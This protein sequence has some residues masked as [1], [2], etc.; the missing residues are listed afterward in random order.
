MR[1]GTD[2]VHARGGLPATRRRAI[3]ALP[4]LGPPRW[5]LN[6]VVAVASLW[7]LW[8]LGVPGFAF[9]TVMPLLLLVAIAG[10]VWT[11][12][13]VGFLL[14]RRRGYA[15]GAAA[16]FAVTPAILVVTAALAIAGVPLQ[17]RWA[18]SEAAFEHAVEQPATA[19]ALRGRIGA[20]RITAVDRV[21]DAV[22]FREASGALMDDAGFAYLP[23]GPTDPV[24]DRFETPQFR[25]LGGGWYAWTSS[26]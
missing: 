23:G 3:A 8:A 26:W 16:W 17:A 25:H 7:L 18:A 13:L 15:T 4:L 11:A 20:Y 9:F 10:V 5:I 2:A 6:G 19:A 24:L 22:I 21:G 1:A 14:R 12:K